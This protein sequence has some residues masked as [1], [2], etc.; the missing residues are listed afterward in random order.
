VVLGATPSIKEMFEADVA[1]ADAVET[2]LPT[3]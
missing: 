3:T 1:A 2:E